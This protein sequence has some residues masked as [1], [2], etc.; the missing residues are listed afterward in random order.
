MEILQEKLPKK[1]IMSACGVDNNQ[2]LIKIGVHLAKLIY[3]E[4]EEEKKEDEVKIIE[5]S[6]GVVTLDDRKELMRKRKAA[7]VLNMKK[8]QSNF[9]VKNK[10]LEPEP[11]D[12]KTKSQH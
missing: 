9:L 10:A 3:G 6:R 8:K 7:M 1:V 11:V 12:I 5:K 4:E 2:K